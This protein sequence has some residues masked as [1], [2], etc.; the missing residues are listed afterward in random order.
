MKTST[1]L[2]ILVILLV[3]TTRLHAA[4]TIQFTVASYTVAESAGA[5]TLTVRRL[6]DTNT[7]VSVDYAS[8]NGTA[9]A[10]LKYTA[11][12]GTLTF[13]AGETNQAIVLPILN[14]GFVEGTKTFQLTLSGP[15]GGAVLGTR[16]TTTVSIRDNDPGV[17]FELTS[18]SVWE[19]ASA[20][21]LP[22]L[23]GNDG[24]LRPFTVDYATRDL[25]AKAG[26]DYQAVAGT[27]E[28]KE[29]ET[30][31]SITIPILPDAV[32]ENTE[33]FQVTLSNPTGGFTLGT[34][35]TAVNI[36]EKYQ[37]LAPPFDSNLSIRRA[38]S[39]NLLDWTGG[40][41]LQ[42]ADRV[43]GPWHTLT[44]ARS[45]AT[46]QSPIP[47]TFYRVT[48]P[49]PAN[50]YVPSSYDGHTPIPLV[51]LL[52]GRASIRHVE[53]YMKFLPLSESR[54]FLYS[55]PDGTI[56]RWG[57]QFWNAT[58][59]TGDFGNTG[60]DDSGYLRG[61]IEEI[62]RRFAVDL[63][64]IYLIGHSNGGFMAYRM[65]CDSSGLI[66]GIASLAGGTFVDPSRCQ[67]SEPV[68]ILEIHGTA[69]DTIRYAGGANTTA[70]VQA[71]MPP[72][73]GALQTVQM[74]AGYNGA[75]DPATDAAPSLDLTTDVAGLD[76][77]VTRY[78]NCPSGGAVE[79]WTING[80][81]HIPTLSSEFS[82]RVIDWLLA[83]PKP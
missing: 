27:I 2:T 81:S 29:N 77:V 21:T 32:A 79:L 10:G 23:R 8:T 14:E 74:W 31:K 24:D 17:G 45:P 42:R 48:R 6:D 35:T 25:T 66:A 53:D 36:E 4:S 11:V 43:T 1:G 12:S 33:R 50:V 37:T 44:A 49:R 47:T 38:G 57:Y 68:N 65:A 54:G 13:A 30:V 19:K 76:T 61:L 69:D 46:V 73:P 52:H 63:K 56:D 82:P 39:V 34:A 9:T 72:Y 58:D 64:R 55:Y 7:V 67:P 26:E 80:G 41:Q 51:I 20:I 78:T 3:C 28:F 71:N 5:V 62:E 59:A 60:V 40:G 22:V 75:R 18:Q 15:M 70:S 16:T 83:H